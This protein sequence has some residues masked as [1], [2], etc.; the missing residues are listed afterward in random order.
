MSDQAQTP[1]Q[2]AWLNDLP[3]LAMALDKDGR[4]AWLSQSLCEKLGL[5]CTELLGQEAASQPQPL[6]HLLAEQNEL[7]QLVPSVGNNVWLH[8]QVSQSQ[9]ADGSPVTLYSYQDISAQ[10]LLE[11]DKERLQQE[12]DTLRLTDPVTGLP[13]QRALSQALERQVSLSRR[14][15]NPL[16]IALFKVN[17]ELRED[18]ENFR[19]MAHYLRDRLRWVDQ[20][21]M[22]GESG[23]LAILPETTEEDALRLASD[24][25]SEHA[26][27][28][29][30]GLVQGTAAWIKGDGPKQLIRRAEEV[31]TEASATS[32]E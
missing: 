2:A 28:A 13:N 11:Q 5:S 20:I 22:W 12:V 1:A 32:A 15:Q 26:E 29:V 19:T 23:F 21:G 7:I 17:A 31:I 3:L 4:I 24:I 27:Q 14:Y 8:T 10:M 18:K 25:V 6:P 30:H 9:A 16:S